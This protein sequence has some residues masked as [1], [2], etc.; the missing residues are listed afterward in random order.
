MYDSAVFVKE[1]END[2]LCKG[3]ESDVNVGRDT[4]YE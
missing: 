3:G 2:D 4:L 1:M